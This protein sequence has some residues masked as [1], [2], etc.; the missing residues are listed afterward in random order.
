MRVLFVTQTPEYGGAEKHMIDLVRRIDSSIHCRILCFSED[1]YSEALNDRPN[2]QVLKLPLIQTKKFRSFFRVFWKHSA[3]VIV[4]VKGIYEHY[5]LS[6]YM[7]ARMSGSHRL[8]AL[9]HLIPDPPPGPEAGRGLWESARRLFGWRTR[10]LLARKV[11]SRLSHVT[12][13]VSEAIRRRLI[14]EYGYPNDQTVTIRN[15]IDLRYYSSPLGQG[16]VKGVVVEQEEIPKTIVCAARLSSVKR[17]DLLLDALALLGKS[18]IGWRCLILGAGPLEGALREQAQRLAL[19][20][21][22]SF[23][24]RVQDVRA[25]LRTADL[26]VLSSEKEGLPLA[27]LEAMAMGVPA[28]V[29]DVGGTGEVVIHGQN[30]LLVKAGSVE[31]LEGAI[32]YL[33]VNH[34]E[35]RRMGEAARLHMQQHFNIE[36]SMDRLKQVLLAARA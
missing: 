27:L 35:R 30:G 17:L 23:V 25:Y 11:Q 24:G 20:D 29:T 15:G 6:A 12:V 36:V 34:E 21:R 16:R 18:Q 5:P 14:Q 19:L 2:V 4:L 3:E 8:I 10:Y 22:V 13:C 26:F 1:F 9:E 28:V 32:A 31:N 7:A 33:L